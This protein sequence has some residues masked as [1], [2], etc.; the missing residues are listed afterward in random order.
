MR[1]AEI[2]MKN[3]CFLRKITG[4]SK[5]KMATLMGIGVASLNKIE[6]GEMP[7][8]LTVEVIFRIEKEFGIPS[9]YQF[10]CLGEKTGG[11]GSLFEQKQL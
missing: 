3:V 11:A 7:E 2:W 9:K 6:R 10:I 8:R 4:L 5:R 1:E